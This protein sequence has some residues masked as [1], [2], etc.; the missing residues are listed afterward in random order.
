MLQA[1]KLHF[2]SFAM[3]SLFALSLSAIRKFTKKIENYS[4]DLNPYDVL[5]TS[6]QTL[7]NTQLMLR[8]DVC[9]E[10]CH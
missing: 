2:L 1:S 5:S 4:I 6:A 9:W 7:A 10:Q 3:F 8:P